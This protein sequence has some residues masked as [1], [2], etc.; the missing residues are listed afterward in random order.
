MPSSAAGAR[1]TFSDVTVAPVQQAIG[2][3]PVQ[4]AA[5]AANQMQNG[6]A[7]GQNAANGGHGEPDGDASAAD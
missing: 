4:V 3:V 5:Q 7:A 1:I 6:Q 2:A